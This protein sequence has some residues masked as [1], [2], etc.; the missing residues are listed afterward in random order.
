VAGLTEGVVQTMHATKLKLVLATVLAIGVTVMGAGWLSYGSLAGAPGLSEAQ[1]DAKASEP[2]D[3]RKV[4]G[5]W[6]VARMEKD[7]KLVEEQVGDMRKLRF[8]FTGEKLYIW[9]VGEKQ[10]RA[11]NYK[12]DPNKRPR[13]VDLEMTRDVSGKPE[14]VRALYE[15]KEKKLLL[16]I[17]NAPDK[18]APTELKS[19]PGTQI[20][21]MELEPVPHGQDVRPKDVLTLPSPNRL[22]SVNNLKQLALAMLNYESTHGSLAPA[23]ISSPEGK[24]LLSWRVAILP[25][26]EQGA[27]YQA[28]KLDEPWDGAN[29]K[30]LLGRMP[31][32]YAPLGDKTEDKNVT[33]YQVF[34]GLGTVFEG[35][36]GIT[37]RNITDGTSNTL[38]IAEAGEPVPWTKPDDLPYSAS[39]SL[40]KLGGLFDGGFHAAFC[41]G[42]VRWIPKKIDEQLLRGFITSNGGEKVSPEDIKP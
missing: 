35:T 24:P 13:A 10:C 25:F 2:S 36:K 6:A 37:L 17:N 40:P 3:A 5:T 8:E 4:I 22:Q 42:A 28:F 34:T 7:G 39:K 18:E 19:K 33:Y 27:L 11:A 12:L 14:H 1:D 20:M 26:I 32:L 21:L 9:S 41:D 15:F 31:K 16:C 30:R 23:A 29:N 38:M